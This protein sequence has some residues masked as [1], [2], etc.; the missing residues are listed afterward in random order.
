LEELSLE[1]LLSI[2]NSFCILLK[3]EESLEIELPISE[4][5]MLD[6]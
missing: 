1:E 5:S 3:E 2:L 4:K 6:R